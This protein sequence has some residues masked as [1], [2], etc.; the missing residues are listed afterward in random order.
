MAKKRRAFRKRSREEWEGIVAEHRASGLCMRRFAKSRRFCE[1][2]LGRWSRLL[3][4]EEVMNSGENPQCGLI[5]LVS[6]EPQVGAM[7]DATKM[8]RLL[9]GTAVCLEL[10]QMPAPDYVAL[11]ARAYEAVSPC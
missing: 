1:T 4:R 2:S 5:E 10:S 6:H 3:R 11:I 8:V 9:V 7:I